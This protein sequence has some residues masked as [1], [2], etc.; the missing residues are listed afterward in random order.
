VASNDAAE[1][2]A[3]PFVVV[4]V[5]PN[6]GCFGVVAAIV[7]SVNCSSVVTASVVAASVDCSGVVTASVDFSGV[8]ANWQAPA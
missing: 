7:D 1:V 6:E 5:G 3:A 4:V 2:P 8:V